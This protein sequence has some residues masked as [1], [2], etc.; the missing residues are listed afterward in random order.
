ML[1]SVAF[2]LGDARYWRADGLSFDAMAMLP[3]G[4]PA[5]PLVR[6][7]HRTGSLV[8]ALVSHNVA[9]GASTLM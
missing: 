8:L 3:T 9:N 4:G 5:L 7:P 2:G 1:W 6:C